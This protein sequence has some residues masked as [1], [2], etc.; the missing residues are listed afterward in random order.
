MT[1][2]FKRRNFA[3]RLRFFA[4]CCYTPTLFEDSQDSQ[5]LDVTIVSLE[6]PGSSCPSAEIWAE[7]TLPWIMLDP[8]LPE[9]PEAK[10]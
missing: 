7:D 1:S 6:D 8:G 10:S 9:Y 3:N 5:C 4:A 2:E